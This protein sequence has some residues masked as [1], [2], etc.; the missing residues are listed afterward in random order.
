MPRSLSFLQPRGNEPSGLGRT[1]RKDCSKSHTCGLWGKGQLMGRSAPRLPPQVAKHWEAQ[2][3]QNTVEP[4]GCGYCPGL[5]CLFHQSL[6]VSN[7]RAGPQNLQRDTCPGCY[8]LFCDS[9]RTQ[10][11]RPKPAVAGLRMSDVTRSTVAGKEERSAF[12]NHPCAKTGGRPSLAH[13]F[14]NPCS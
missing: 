12:W 8:L 9:F 5:G 13:R 4:A 2:L 14:V 10:L 3:G 11:Q 1:F 6:A 7:Q